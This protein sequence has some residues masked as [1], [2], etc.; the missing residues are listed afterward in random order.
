[1]VDAGVDNVLF[2]D[3][4][5]DVD[6]ALTKLI[7][8][9]PLD[10][11]G[12]LAPNTSASRI[13]EIEKHSTGYLYGVSLLGV[14]GARDELLPKQK[15]CLKK[16]KKQAKLPVM[17]G[18]GLSTPE[19]LRQVYA[20]GVQ[21]AVIG[22]AGVKHLEEGKRILSNRVADLRILIQ[23]VEGNRTWSREDQANVISVLRGY[24]ME[25]IEVTIRAW[26]R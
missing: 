9:S 20:C 19:H 26:Q 4:P 2:A 21:A 11:I 24:R 3:A 6:P 14:T 17:V 12:L 23:T 13:K 7:L 16:W 1:M 15:S 18:F 5:F 22:S 25:V 10:N 8:D